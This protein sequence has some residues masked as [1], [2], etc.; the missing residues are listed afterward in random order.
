ME[1]VQFR[2]QQ[3]KAGVSALRASGTGGGG[4]ARIAAHGRGAGLRGVCV[5]GA[6]FERKSFAGR[7]AAMLHV[8]QKT[9][10]RGARPWPGCGDSTS[11]FDGVMSD[12]RYLPPAR[13][14][15]RPIVLRVGGD[16]VGT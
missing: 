7:G 14:Q 10:H 11:R 4:D 8:A 13:R 16:D 12:P 9:H 6:W 1:R 5:A 2:A 3:M 15:L